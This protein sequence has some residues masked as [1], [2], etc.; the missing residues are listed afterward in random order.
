MPWGLSARERKHGPMCNP[1]A[2]PTQPGGSAERS[3][4]HA[5]SNR[6]SLTFAAPREHES[7]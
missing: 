7:T 3:A 1:A 6:Y 5:A 2:A 4:A